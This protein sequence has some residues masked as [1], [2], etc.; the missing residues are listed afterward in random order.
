MKLGHLRGGGRRRRRVSTLGVRD[1]GG[2]GGRVG[3]TAG[4]GTGW[5]STTAISNWPVRLAGQL[6]DV[7]FQHFLVSSSLGEEWQQ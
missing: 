5:G 1:S 3:A 7:S 6:N 4:V 2:G